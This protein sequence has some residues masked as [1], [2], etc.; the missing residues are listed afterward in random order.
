[1]PVSK[2]LPACAAGVL[3]LLLC[4]SWWQSSRYSDR[5]RFHLLGRTVETFSAN[6]T[7]RISFV[8]GIVPNPGDRRHF[9]QRNAGGRLAVNPLAIRFRT[10]RDLFEVSLGHWHLFSAALAAL[11]LTLAREGGSRAEGG[12]GHGSR[13]QARASSGDGG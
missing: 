9:R 3:L 8:N 11:V 1:M 4:I 13:R 5:Y 12:R 7:V 2:Y 10:Q 6:S